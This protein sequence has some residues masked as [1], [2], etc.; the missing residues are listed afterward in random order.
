MR[1]APRNV[2][3]SAAEGASA[4]GALHLLGRTPGEPSG[5]AVVVAVAYLHHSK[6]SRARRHHTLPAT[7]TLPPPERNK[8][9]EQ[10]GALSLCAAVEL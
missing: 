10:H 1:E 2:V 5:E 6:E 8:A 9:R 3:A 4:V 7:A